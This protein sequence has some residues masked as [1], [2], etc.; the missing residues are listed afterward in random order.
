MTWDD[1]HAD[2]L[3][4]FPKFAGKFYLAHDITQI[5]ESLLIIRNFKPSEAAKLKVSFA[6]EVDVIL[7]GKSINN[8]CWI[9]IE[10]ER[11]ININHYPGYKSFTH[12]GD[13][14]HPYS[15]KFGRYAGTVSAEVLKT[16]CTNI[17]D[18]NITKQTF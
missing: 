17:Y 2:L 1:L 12:D 10:K 16:I 18:G 9:T 5:S 4:H 3:S 8:K 13:V 7:E 6:F 15:V 14:F 11:T